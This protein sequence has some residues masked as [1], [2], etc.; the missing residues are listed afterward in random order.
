MLQE[1]DVLTV[2]KDE[3]SQRNLAFIYQHKPVQRLIGRAFITHL[4]NQWQYEWREWRMRVTMDKK[5]E[6]RKPKQDGKRKRV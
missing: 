5:K 6:T 2:K 4:E 1:V 3:D